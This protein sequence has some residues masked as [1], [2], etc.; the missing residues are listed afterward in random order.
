MGL[1]FG[2]GRA[3][4]E[5]DGELDRRYCK[6]CL[7]RSIAD[8]AVYSYFQEGSGA[9]WERWVEVGKVVSIGCECVNGAV[10]YNFPWE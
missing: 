2:A 5:A 8:S 10:A 3:W 7:C 1:G 9:H 6:Y 4:E